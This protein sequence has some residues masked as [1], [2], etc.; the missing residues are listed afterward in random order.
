MKTNTF[1]FILLLG[2]LLH[3]AVCGTYSALITNET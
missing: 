1:T 2:I 3:V